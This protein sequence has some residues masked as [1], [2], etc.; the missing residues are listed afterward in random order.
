MTKEEK[1]AA[2]YEGFVDGVSSIHSILTTLGNESI[3]HYKAK[4]YNHIMQLI[5]HTIK[6]VA[7]IVNESVKKLETRKK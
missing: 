3:K 6:G 2:Y 7:Q 1:Q 5:A 4:Q